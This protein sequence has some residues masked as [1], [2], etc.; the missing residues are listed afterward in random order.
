M[1]RLTKPWLPLLFVHPFFIFRHQDHYVGSRLWIPP[2]SMEIKK[3]E[4]TVMTPHPSIRESDDTFQNDILRQVDCLVHTLKHSRHLQVD[5]LFD[6]TKRD[7]NMEFLISPKEFLSI[8]REKKWLK[9]HNENWVELLVA[10][11]PWLGEVPIKTCISQLMELIGEKTMAIG[12]VLTEYEK[13]Y[14]DIVR[15]PKPFISYPEF[16]IVNR[17]IGIHRNYIPKKHS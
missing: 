8:A 13:N 17:C 3:E 16:S 12:A 10:T 15:L 6:Q 2:D 5:A 11:P 4:I 14:H 9:V 1:L 7:F